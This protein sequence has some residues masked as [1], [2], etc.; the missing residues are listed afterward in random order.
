MF[1]AK[2]NMEPFGANE[3][4]APPPPSPKNNFVFVWKGEGGDLK[5]EAKETRERE[6]GR[7][8]GHKLSS[9]RIS[10]PPCPLLGA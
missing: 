6:R 1:E 7:I 3:N 5:G 8:R 4:L 2:R 10:E 9:A